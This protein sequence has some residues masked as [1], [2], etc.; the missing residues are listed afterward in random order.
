M[1]GFVPAGSSTRAEDASQGVEQSAAEP[2]AVEPDV[3]LAACSSWRPC[4]F[5]RC[6]TGGGLEAQAKAD[7]GGGCRG[8][9]PLLP[10]IDAACVSTR[11][12][13]VSK[14]PSCA[15]PQLSSDDNPPLSDQSH[16]T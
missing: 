2:V 6:V 8:P 14:R 4:C 10:A 11:P 1:V 5:P 16:G 9:M 15:T 3:G 7:M 13:T 12:H